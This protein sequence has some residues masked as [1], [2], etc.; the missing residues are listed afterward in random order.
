VSQQINLF[1]PAL[2]QKKKHFSTVMML[3]SLLLI[4]ICGL[5]LMAFLDYRGGALTSQADI[6]KVQLAAREAKLVK[7]KAQYPP[8][9]KSVEL[10]QQVAA[11]ELA[12]TALKGAKEE[13]ERGEFGNAQG[14]S[15]YFSALARQT[16]NGLWLTGLTI[17]GTGDI[18]IEGRTLRAELVPQLILRLSKEPAFQGKSFANLD[19][20]LAP[21]EDVTQGKSVAA[22]VFRLQASGGA[23]A[24]LPAA[25][26]AGVA[27]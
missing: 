20:G 21:S 1:N 10:V 3:Q 25:L 7:V 8:R 26:P 19:I 4:G 17:S 13:L 6:G 11:A 14:H 9:K 24:A 12:L 22:L 2:S 16:V 23:P 5:C 15:A 27:R 18:G